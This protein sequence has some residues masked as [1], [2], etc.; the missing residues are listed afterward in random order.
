MNI[1]MHGLPNDE[2]LVSQVG[3][4]IWR[5]LIS[6]LPPNEARECAVTNVS[7]RSFNHEGKR[8]PFLRI[9]SDKRSDFEAA[10][11]LL[12]PIRLPGAPRKFIEYVLLAGCTED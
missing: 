5:Q 3:E 4:A 1:E 12:G 9:Y 8:V 7:S 2:S 6:T 11:K 10:R